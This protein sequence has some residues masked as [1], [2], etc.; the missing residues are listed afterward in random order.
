MLS[1]PLP[2]K[3]APA[4]SEPPLARLSLGALVGY[5]SSAGGPHMPHML[6][7]LRRITLD[8]GESEAGGGGPGDAPG[9][10]ARLHAKSFSTT[11][12]HCW[13]DGDCVVHDCSYPVQMQSTGQPVPADKPPNLQMTGGTALIGSRQHHISQITYKCDVHGS[14]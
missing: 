5:S 3:P 7:K 8:R 9:F 11:R 12:G 1:Q 10:K 13:C 14:A 2:A 6:D 4:A